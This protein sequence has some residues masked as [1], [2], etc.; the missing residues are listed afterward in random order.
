M[1]RIALLV[2]NASGVYR[3]LAEAEEV[4]HRRWDEGQR[5]RLKNGYVAEDYPRQRRFDAF[6]AALPVNVSTGEIWGWNAAKAGA[7]NVSRP[8][9]RRPGRAI[10]RPDD[11]ITFTDADWAALFIEENG[12]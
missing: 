5:R 9:G 1:A 6:A 10:V 11:T 2:G 7:P 3:F 12:L 8:P 4:E